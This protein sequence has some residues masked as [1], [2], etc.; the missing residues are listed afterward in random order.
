MGNELKMVTD[1]V[2]SDGKGAAIIP[3]SPM[4]RYS[5]KLHDRIETE[6]P[7][8]VFKQTSS[9]QGS[10]QR[11]PGIFTSSSLSFEEALF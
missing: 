9:D 2:V 8:G 3:F 4:L 1:N 6:R 5:P 11:K 10:F 7:F